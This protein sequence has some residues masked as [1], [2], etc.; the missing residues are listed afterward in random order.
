MSLSARTWM[1]GGRIRASDPA[2]I[3][4]KR[5]GDRKKKIDRMFKYWEREKKRHRGTDRQTDIYI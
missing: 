1:R 3:E 5:G 2:P 4:L